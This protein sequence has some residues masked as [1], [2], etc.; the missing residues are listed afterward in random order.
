M[1]VMIKYRS[2]MIKFDDYDYCIIQPK[3]WSLY[4]L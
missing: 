4:V 3:E 2:A 1:G